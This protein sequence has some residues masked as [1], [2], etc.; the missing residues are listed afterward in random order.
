MAV[1]TRCM[2]HI[3]VDAALA[4]AWFHTPPAMH[5]HACMQAEEPS[6]DSPVTQVNKS[7]NSTSHDHW[8][9]SQVCS[10]QMWSMQECGNVNQGDVVWVRQCARNATTHTCTRTSNDRR[11]GHLNSCSD[12]LSVECS[13]V[14]HS[15]ASLHN[16]KRSAGVDG[17]RSRLP[18]ARHHRSNCNQ[19]CEHPSWCSHHDERSVI[20]N[21]TLITTCSN[22]VKAAQIELDQFACF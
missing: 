3:N 17:E 6:T 18:C 20:S 21:Y 22:T 19:R 2:E 13:V 11:V 16:V 8:R 7:N 12:V 5:V 4:F 15:A 1:C 10:S 14:A 9:I